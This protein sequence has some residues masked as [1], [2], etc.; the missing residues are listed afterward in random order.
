MPLSVFT[1]H[2]TGCKFSRDRACRRCNCPKWVGGQ[3]NGYYFRQGAKTRKWAVAE[4]MRLKLE[5]AL[6]KVWRWSIYSVPR[7]RLVVQIPWLR[8]AYL[9][10]Y[11]A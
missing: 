1:R 6:A 4:E 10:Q 8:W 5:E 7:R 9:S 3:V 2:S 11:W